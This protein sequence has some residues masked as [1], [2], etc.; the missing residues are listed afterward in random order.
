[1]T[2]TSHSDSQ[3]QLWMTMGRLVLVKSAKM[4]WC[5]EWMPRREKFSEKA[6]QAS[7]SRNWID[8]GVGSGEVDA[9][10]WRGFRD[11]VDLHLDAIDTDYHKQKREGEKERERDNQKSPKNNS[12]ISRYIKEKERMHRNAWTCDMPY[13]KHHR[14]SPIQSY[15]HKISCTQLNAW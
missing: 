13:K 7:S 5:S 11:G 4:T 15:Q 10:E 3:P 6:F 9:L 12:N 8:E 14:L 1:M 2:E